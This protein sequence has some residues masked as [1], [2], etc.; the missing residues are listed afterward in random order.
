MIKDSWGEH[1]MRKGP[2]IEN[3]EDQPTKHD[4][5]ELSRYDLDDLGGDFTRNKHSWNSNEVSGWIHGWSDRVQIA[6]SQNQ[7]LKTARK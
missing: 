4:W 6:S 7:N 1:C 3:E 2:K 5:I